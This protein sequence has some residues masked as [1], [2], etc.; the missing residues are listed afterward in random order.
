MSNGFE[1]TNGWILS[2]AYAKIFFSAET[3]SSKY[4]VYTPDNSL[5]GWTMVT[6]VRGNGNAI[7]IYFNGVQ[8]V[9]TG[10]FSSP[11][12]STNDLTFGTSLLFPDV[13]GP[14]WYD[15]DMWQPQIWST[16]LTPTEVA[17]LYFQQ[18]G[19]ADWP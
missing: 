9:T 14:P 15:G 6:I 1:N 12:S 18:V 17:N 16:A 7:A 11:A 2:T 4:T 5:D 8:V 10:S 3:T 13:Q 19:G